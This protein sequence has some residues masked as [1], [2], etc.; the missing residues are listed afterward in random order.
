[1]YQRRQKQPPITS[2]GGGNESFKTWSE[3]MN[4]TN[5]H[6]WQ[7]TLCTWRSVAVCSAT[8]G[9]C[10]FCNKQCSFMWITA[11]SKSDNHGL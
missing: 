2:S 1:M 7:K 9:Y 4:L 10:L 6:R 11:Y 3:N 5:R 8:C